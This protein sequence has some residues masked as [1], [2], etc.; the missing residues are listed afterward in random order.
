MKSLR[1]NIFLGRVYNVASSCDI[2]FEYVESD[3]FHGCVIVED[4]RAKRS[5]AHT[6]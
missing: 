3:Q 1:K 4:M 5:N 6:W 2:R